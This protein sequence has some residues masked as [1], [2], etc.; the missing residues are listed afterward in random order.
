M[1]SLR[2]L[3]N[4]L[5]TLKEDREQD[6]A[7]YQ[8]GYTAGVADRKAYEGDKDAPV[9][10]KANASFPWSEGYLDGWCDFKALL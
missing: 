8:A 5:S 1:P 7:E 10:G 6:R 2:R 4:L 3:R 9:P